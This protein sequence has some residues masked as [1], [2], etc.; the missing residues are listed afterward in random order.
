MAF[1]TFHHLPLGADPATK[2]WMK[3]TMHPIFGF[4]QLARFSWQ[5]AARAME[6]GGPA[7]QWWAPSTCHFGQEPLV[8][9]EIV[10]I[11]D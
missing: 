2:A 10:P 4:P 1:L 3:Q 8:H 11:L 6:E 5:P 9:T 7:V